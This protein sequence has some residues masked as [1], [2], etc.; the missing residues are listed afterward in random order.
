MRKDDDDIAEQSHPSRGEWIEITPVG[1]MYSSVPCLTPRGVSGLKYFRQ[2]ADGRG[3][4]LTPRGVS[5]LKLNKEERRFGT[6]SLT[7]RG[8]SGL[9][10]G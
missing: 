1:L 10:S 8:V 3:V 4:C 9:K 7:P 5:G 6:T 2:L